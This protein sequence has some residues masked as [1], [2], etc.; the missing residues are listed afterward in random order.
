MGESVNLT[1]FR[2]LQLCFQDISVA[3][4]DY[5][6]RVGTPPTGNIAAKKKHRPILV[7]LLREEHQRY[8]YRNRNI[9]RDTDEFSSVF[10]NEDLP[11]IIVQRRA[12]VRSVY[13]NA[14][15]KGH[16]A[17]MIGTKVIVDI[18]YKHRDLEKLPQ[19][20]KLSDSKI[21]NVKGGLAFA[22]ANAYLSNFFRCDLEYNGLLFDSA[23]RAYQFERCKRLG[24]PEIAQQVLDAKDAKACK[25]ASWYV[26]STPEWDAQ[27]RG[28]M[29]EIVTE[30]FS[31]N[32]LLLESLLATGK[33]A[34][35]E[36]TTDMF[37]GAATVIGSKLLKNG[38][39]KGRNELG[40]ILVEVREE[41]K[42]ERN[43]VEMRSSSSDDQGNIALSSPR[44]SPSNSQERANQADQDSP[45]IALSQST[46][47][48]S[49]RRSGHNANTKLKKNKRNKN[50]NFDGNNDMTIDGY[51][52]L[53]GNQADT[54]LTGAGNRP[55]ALPGPGPT[56]SHTHVQHDTS[57]TV[58]NVPAPTPHSWSAPTHT[59]LQP[60]PGIGVL[61]L[62]GSLTWPFSAFHQICQAQ[63]SYKAQVCLHLHLGVGF[64]RL[65]CSSLL[66]MHI[67][68]RLIVRIQ[69]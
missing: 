53:G 12:D 51:Q 50:R 19:G 32:D 63:N 10:I 13:L 64:I 24:A 18:P 44:P 4:I 65:I 46:Q 20:L 34:L 23:E 21:V 25:Q 61:P 52:A 67:L 41:L 36:A 1:A 7:K 26:K 33:K 17:K 42:R 27:K 28:I 57:N 62:P 56:S 49:V 55:V 30:K 68:D 47:N 48:I 11:Q 45:I 35:I 39:W 58:G 69:M 60:H 43:W 14:I 3:D 31:Q 5:C 38:S 15:E 54:Q 2:I 16:D 59:G 22:T 29:K 66:L 6:Y 9:L 8:I 40:L 37:W